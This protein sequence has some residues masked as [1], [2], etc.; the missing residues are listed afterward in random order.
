MNYDPKFV[1]NKLQNS[2]IFTYVDSTPNEPFLLKFKLDKKPISIHKFNI[3][4]SNNNSTKKFVYKFYMEKSGNVLSV[5]FKNK[6]MYELY[7]KV[8][9]IFMCGINSSDLNI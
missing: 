7:S 8:N 4:I 2:H 5:H 1:L 9:F 3:V 6:N